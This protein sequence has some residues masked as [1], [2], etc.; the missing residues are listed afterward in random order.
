MSYRLR[1]HALLILYPLCVMKISRK[2]VKSMVTITMSEKLSIILGY[3]Q[4]RPQA[5]SQKDASPKEASFIPAGHGTEDT[6]TA[7]C[8]T[9]S[10]SE[11]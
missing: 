8:T 1:F 6:S 3:L 11:E 10:M 4:S 2:Q 7:S 5:S 9:R